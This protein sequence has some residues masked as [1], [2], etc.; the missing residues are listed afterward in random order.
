[1]IELLIFGVGFF[2]GKRWNVWKWRFQITVI[3]KYRH[4]NQLMDAHSEACRKC[5]KILEESGLCE[6]LELATA[7]RKAL[8]AEAQ[9]ASPVREP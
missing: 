4:W 8:Y 1:M 6:E 9:L 5:S 7:E 3:P 2:V